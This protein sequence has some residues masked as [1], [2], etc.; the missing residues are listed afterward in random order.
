[1][2]RHAAIEYLRAGPGV[3]WR[4]EEGG[5]V[6]SW[7]DGTTILFREEL[8]VLVERLA[9]GRLPAFAAL[10]IL[11][12][13][14]R[15]KTPAP[16]AESEQ[17]PDG[18]KQ[19]LLALKVQQRQQAVDVLA[20]VANLPRELI[21]RAPGKALFA[22]AV[23]EQSTRLSAEESAAVARGLP[24]AWGGDELNTPPPDA[25]P[26]D[27]E[28]AL[29]DVALGLSRHT[30]ESLT[31]RLR[32]GLDA[33]PSAA[34]DLDL[35]RGEQA[36]RLLEALEQDA[37]QAGL[38]LV[39]RDLMAALRLPRTLTLPDETASEGVSD[40]GN[41]G[42]LD[43]LVLSELA[44]D[45][46]TLATRVALNEALYLRREPPAQRPQRSL[47]LLLDAGVRMWGVP[48]VL[49]V[50]S[51]LA[52]IS[53]HP[54]ACAALAWRAKGRALVPV[55]LL[56][57][58]G[59]E[60]H[61]AALATE[62]HPGAALPALAKALE[63]HPEV[64]AVIVTHRA[65]LAD[66]GFQAQLAQLKVSR[67]FLVLVE[68]DGL[69]ELHPLPWG[70]PRPLAEVRIDVNKLFLR[71]KG[72]PGPAP[73][74]AG[75][76]NDQPAIFREKPFPLLLPVT[77]KMELAVRTNKEGGGLCA[78]TDRRLFAWAES[79]IG[80]RLIATNLPG[81][82][83]FWL[84]LTQG[85]Q[86]V[87]VRGR[88]GDGKMAVIVTDFQGGEPRVARFT[89]HSAL[90]AWIERHVVL[91]ALHTCVI[92]VELAT[93]EVLAET[94]L[95]AGTSWISGRYFYGPDG[96]C[97]AAWDGTA[98][99]WTKLVAG[100]ALKQEQVVLVFDRD[101]IGAWVVTNDGRVLSP[102]GSEAMS[103]GFPVEEGRVL[104]E[105]NRLA[106]KKP[107]VDGWEFVD[108]E[109]KTVSALHMASTAAIRSMEITPPARSLQSNFTSISAVPGQPLRL[110][111]KRGRWQELF[112]A[113]G[114]ALLWVNSTEKEAVLRPQARPLT[115]ISA[116]SHLGGHLRRADW[117]GGNRAWLDGRGLLHLKPADPAAPEVTLTLSCEAAMAAWSTDGRRCGPQFFHG[118][119]FEDETK[120]IHELIEQFCKTAC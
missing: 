37:E 40:I 101:G 71:P 34:P 54:A 1:M 103:I 58:A 14:A 112:L 68:R 108:L 77:G 116:S 113:R 49:G 11:L 106:V 64:D 32:T 3:P 6:L 102:T 93:G 65:A 86:V 48:R 67:G 99:A 97:F 53:R 10:V 89:G 42:P 84:K 81:G 60:E 98:V 109:K 57:K 72:K 24:E 7:K 5:A 74:L 115:P 28:R 88:A 75:Q 33:V 104:E 20:R 17:A 114:S 55:N 82:R 78:M 66:L 62:L 19:L 41:R 25:P 120:A 73:L 87:V 18:R 36:R 29:Q 23:F 51:A 15:G 92:T 9:P 38:A 4:W 26:P 107:R 69:V 105:G 96:L 59:M 52:L 94:S 80:A 70:A 91:V 8:L 85:G 119:H 100:S 111:T 118:E 79:G 13:A 43:R 110:C 21:A 16:A 63:E 22:E 61:L 46:L 56:T 117:P 83:T 95:P 2:S 12:A 39:V 27:L 44:H 31:L 30:A 47:A 90:A 45:D 50:A 76:P 35:P